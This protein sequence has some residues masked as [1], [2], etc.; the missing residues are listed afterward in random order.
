MLLASL[1]AVR[2]GRPSVE[3]ALSNL[4]LPAP[5]RATRRDIVLVTMESTLRLGNRSDASALVARLT[6]PVLQRDHIRALGQIAGPD[7]VAPLVDCLLHHE[8]SLARIEAARA[9]RHIGGPLVKYTLCHVALDDPELKVR[10]AAFIA[11]LDLA[12]AGKRL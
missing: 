3:I 10:Q 4:P 9:L 12:G 5:I 2:L 7:A 8:S 11:W 6:D 1:L